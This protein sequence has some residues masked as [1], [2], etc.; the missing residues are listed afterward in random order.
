VQ[1]VAVTLTPP[2]AATEGITLG[3]PAGD[4]IAALLC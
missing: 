2:F 1:G 4:G 3:M